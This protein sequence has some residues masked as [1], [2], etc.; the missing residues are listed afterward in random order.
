MLNSPFV[1]QQS[2]HLADKLL[3][4]KHA[5][6]SERIRD[7]YRLIAGIEPAPSDIARVKAFLPRYAATWAKQHPGA[8]RTAATAHLALVSNDP[9]PI[10]AGI[11]REDGLAQDDDA[12]LP[13][14]DKDA[15]PVIAA[16]SA[17]EAAWSAFVQALYGSAA[18]QFVR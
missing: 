17:A 2:L 4:E 1:R 12:D 5:T 11:V 16:D 6:D 15:G 9:G 7:A 3:A 14:H 13:K 18:F 8:G 10:T